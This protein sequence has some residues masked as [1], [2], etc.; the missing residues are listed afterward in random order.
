VGPGTTTPNSPPCKE[1][2][3]STTGAADEVAKKAPTAP[4]YGVKYVVKWYPRTTG[5]SD[6]VATKAPTAPVYDKDI[7]I[8]EIYLYECLT[9]NPK[10]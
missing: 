10:P 3:P 7:E 8:H 6:Q 9:L 4:V 2:Y 5:A 1:W